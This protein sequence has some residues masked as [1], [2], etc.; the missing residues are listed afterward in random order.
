[1]NK[2]IKTIL[3]VIGVVVLLALF[4]IITM[5]FVKDGIT[6]MKKCHYDLGNNITCEYMSGGY[7]TRFSDCSDGYTHIGD[8]YKGVCKNE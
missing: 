6:N 5:N 2:K 1:M 3:I 7:E 4:V 8:K